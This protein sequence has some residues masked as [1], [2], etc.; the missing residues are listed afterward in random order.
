MSRQYSPRSV[1]KGPK[2]RFVTVALDEKTRFLI[3]I[4]ARKERR[5]VSSL[6]NEAVLSYLPTLSFVEG[7]RPTSLVE[8]VEEIWSPFAATRFVLQADRLPSTLTFTEQILWQMIQGDP[9]LWRKGPRGGWISRDGNARNGIKHEVLRQKWDELKATA[10][11]AAELEL[12]RSGATHNP[13]IQKS[14]PESIFD[15]EPM[16]GGK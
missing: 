14:V 13:A 12:S 9:E 5:T 16:K 2:G 3:E 1:D 8:I 15:S 6:I 10:E 11:L 4:A 7:N